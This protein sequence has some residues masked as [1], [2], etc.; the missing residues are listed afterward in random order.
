MSSEGVRTPGPVHSSGEAAWVTRALEWRQPHARRSEWQLFAGGE[1]I[2]ALRIQGVFREES[3]AEGPS[4]LWCFRGG[5]GHTEISLAGT[6]LPAAR[7]EQRW[8]SGRVESLGSGL[9]WQWSRHGFVRPWFLLATESDT[10]CVLVRPS[11]GLTRFG[12]VVTIEPAGRRIAEIEPLV[13]LL[14][15]VVLVDHRRAHAT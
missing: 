10:P 6:T 9:R 2:G 13:L 14:W 3:E 15:Q 1:R 7:Y 11:S 8:F 12:A 5:G 4:G